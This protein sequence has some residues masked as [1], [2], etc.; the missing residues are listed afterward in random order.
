[1]RLFSQVHIGNFF[2]L[3]LIIS[4]PSEAPKV[5]FIQ[6]L[7]FQEIWL[8][9]QKRLHELLYI[10]IEWI[11]NTIHDAQRN[12]DPFLNLEVN[13]EDAPYTRKEFVSYFGESC[14]KLEIV[15]KI[16]KS[17]RICRT[18][19]DSMHEENILVYLMIS[20]LLY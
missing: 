14:L 5:A 3:I 2:D 7:R 11:V 10:V 19:W 18:A 17:W 9:R 13:R 4:S 20:K 12:F 1:M 6:C 15:R 16:G 8:L